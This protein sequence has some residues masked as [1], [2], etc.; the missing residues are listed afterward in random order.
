MAIVF[1]SCG[2]VAPNEERDGGTDRGLNVVDGVDQGTQPDGV[3][4]GQTTPGHASTSPT[5]QPPASPPSAD[6]DPSGGGAKSGPANGSPTIDLAADFQ[7][8]ARPASEDYQTLWATY[9]YTPRLFHVDAGYELLQL[10]GRPLGPRLS[11]VGW[12]QSAME[13]SVQIFFQDTWRTYN[14]AGVAGT[15]Q[16]DCSEYYDHPVGR[17]RYKIARGEFGDGVRNY[18]LQP[19][20]T[21]AVDPEV[22]SYGSVVYIPSARGLEFTLPNGQK[23]VHDGYFFAGDTGGLINGNHIDVFLG[24][25][26]KTPFSW[27]T[28]RS[29]SR[30]PYEVVDNAEIA[31]ALLRL[32]IGN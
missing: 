12:C 11:K 1:V 10:D 20:R 21:I 3:T 29:S 17:T 4:S 9:Y 24:I 13:G 18:V 2:F 8:P 22:I 15:V 31:E 16:V 28:S 23:R 5:T 19:F 32:H 26:T 30:I 6:T 25:A 27:I 14:Y 7:L